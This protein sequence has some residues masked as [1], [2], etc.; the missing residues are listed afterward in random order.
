[1]KWI[2]RMSK[3][4]PMLQ[5]VELTI[6]GTD[7]RLHG[8]TV[9][10]Q[11]TLPVNITEATPLAAIQAIRDWAEQTLQVTQATA[12]N[13][14]ELDQSLNPPVDFNLSI[15]PAGAKVTLPTDFDWND[16]TTWPPGTEMA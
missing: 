1:M 2:S 14:A 15:L 12:T 7:Y 13:V 5:A 9:T 11:G 4:T 16:P 8:C 10:I 6:T 3:H